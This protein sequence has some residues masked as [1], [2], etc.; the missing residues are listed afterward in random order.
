MIKKHI[1]ITGGNNGI[2]RALVEKFAAK[3]WQVIIVGRRSEFLQDDVSQYQDSIGA[4]TAGVG[5]H[6]DR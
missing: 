5:E 6:G 3:G 2:G 4:I 1:L